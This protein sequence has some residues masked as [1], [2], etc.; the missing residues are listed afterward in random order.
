V[1]GIGLGA[2]SDMLVYY[3]AKETVMGAIGGLTAP[4]FLIVFRWVYRHFRQREALS[5]PWAYALYAVC[6]ALA[7]LLMIGAT[8][9]LPQRP[10]LELGGWLAFYPLGSAVLFPLIGVLADYVQQQRD[11]HEQTKEIFGK[12]VSESIARRILAER[13]H[14]SLKGE[15]RHVTVLFS[16]IRGFTRMVKE[17]GA[18]EVVHTL[19]EYFATMIDIIFPYDGTINKFIGDAI[20]VLYGAPLPLGDE[21]YRAVETAKTMIQVLKF[22]NQERARHGKPPIHIGIGIDAGQVVCGNVGSLRRLEYTGIGAPVNN[23]TYLGALAPEN[24]VYIGE[25]AYREIEG[26]VRVKPVGP[27]QLKGGTGEMMVYALDEDGS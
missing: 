7:G 10:G 26:R 8:Y 13:D 18:E 2:V 25:N 24:T 14:I 4:L 22:L 1:L 15:K 27:V 21:S 23:A 9:L 12:Y 16:D 5:R 20:V 11:E 17:L 3:A 6:G 19:N